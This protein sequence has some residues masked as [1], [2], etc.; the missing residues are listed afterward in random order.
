VQHLALACLAALA[1]SSKSAIRRFTHSAKR[2]IVTWQIRF[3]PRM[4]GRKRSPRLTKSAGGGSP[5]QH[6]GQGLPSASGKPNSNGFDS[7]GGLFRTGLSPPLP[8]A[9][10]PK[11]DTSV[12]PV[13]PLNLFRRQ[14]HQ[15]A[16]TTR[17]HC[18]YEERQVST[19]RRM[20]SPMGRSRITPH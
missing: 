6:V 18:Y 10:R 1:K 2:R 8:S 13:S 15:Q 19:H 20:K 9:R 14:G 4:L 17:A 11:E 3:P 16:F 7:D 5:T 12:S